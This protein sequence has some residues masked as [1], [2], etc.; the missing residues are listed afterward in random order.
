MTEV[1]PNTVGRLAVRGPTGCRYLDD[2]RQM[3]YV[4]DGWNF[5]GDAYL[6]DEDG[7]FWFQARAG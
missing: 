3:S 2:E 7:Y 1:P 6:V 4:R 5:S